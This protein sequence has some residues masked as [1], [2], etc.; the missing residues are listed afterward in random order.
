[1]PEFRA[2]R[3]TRGRNAAVVPSERYE[4][5]AAAAVAVLLNV[6]VLALLANAMARKP[7]ASDDAI[8]SI[9]VRWIERKDKPATEPAHATRVARPS[10]ALQARANTRTS[11]QV[12][13]A[14]NSVVSLQVPRVADDRWPLTGN[15]PRRRSIGAMPLPHDPLRLQRRVILD[16]AEQPGRFAM[17]D[18]SLRARLAG[19]SRRASCGE[20]RML[21]NASPSM[22]LKQSVT[23]ESLGRYLQQE[24]W[25]QDEAEQKTLD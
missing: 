1:M 20:V 21:A 15:I 14:D 19:L 9:E 11:P 25:K 24:C 22:Q 4:N 7:T 18:H 17:Q 3:R 12:R 10:H 8:G 2:A 16:V 5:N 6:A 13:G 23:R